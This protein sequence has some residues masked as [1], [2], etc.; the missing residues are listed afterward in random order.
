MRAAV[1]LP[2]KTFEVKRIFPFRV[3]KL[4]TYLPCTPIHFANT[5]AFTAP[6]WSGPILVQRRLNPSCPFTHRAVLCLSKRLWAERSIN[7]GLQ[8]LGN[9]ND[10][11]IAS[12]SARIDVQ[13][14]YT[15]IVPRKQSLHSRTRNV[16]PFIL[17]SRLH[18][19]FSHTPNTAQVLGRI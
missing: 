3:L 7:S 2:S 19:V 6:P 4:M 1:A 18:V 5:L 8:I 10:C 15:A 11:N 12:E 9:Y 16:W 13:S 14:S 17:V